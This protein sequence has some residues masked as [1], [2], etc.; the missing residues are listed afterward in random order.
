MR[1][2]QRIWMVILVALALPALL[3][4]GQTASNPRTSGPARID[5]PSEVSQSLNG[6]EILRIS[7]TSIQINRSLNA[8]DFQV[9]HE[10]E[11]P[12]NSNPAAG[13]GRTA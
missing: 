3:A 5:C 8:S 12:S 4:D 2:F 9:Q 13:H 6:S 11:G 1:R 7:N 10:G